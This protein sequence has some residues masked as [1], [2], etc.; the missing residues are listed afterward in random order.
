MGKG[1]MNY[2]IWNK[3]LVQNNTEDLENQVSQGQEILKIP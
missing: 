2:L 1:L 3:Q